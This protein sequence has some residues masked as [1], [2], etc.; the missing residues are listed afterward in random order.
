MTDALEMVNLQSVY[1]S[2]D[3]KKM[4]MRSTLLINQVQMARISQGTGDLL[5]FLIKENY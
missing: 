1:L 3:T 2:F 4:T 5:F